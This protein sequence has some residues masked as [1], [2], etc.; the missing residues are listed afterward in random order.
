MATST[1]GAQPIRRRARYRENVKS[2]LK[3]VARDTFAAN[4]FGLFNM[5]G[6]VAEWVADYYGEDTYKGG[7]KKNPTGPALGKERVV[8]GGSFDS[9][10]D[11][12][13]VFQREKH[14]PADRESWLG[15]RIVLKGGGS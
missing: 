10:E 13:R 15:F 4:P 5:A 7:T 6:N 14:N 1:R 11:D 2:P 9:S 12:L 8:R 3:T